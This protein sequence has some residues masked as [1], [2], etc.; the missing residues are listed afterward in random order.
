MADD[1]N[2]LTQ[3]LKKSGGDGIETNYYNILNRRTAMDDVGDAFTAQ[4]TQPAVNGKQKMT[5]ALM[6]GVGAGFKASQTHIRDKK[7][8]EVEGMLKEVVD[9]RVKLQSQLGKQQLTKATFANYAMDN[10]GDFKKVNDALAAND[11]VAVNELMPL[12]Y[13]R[14]SEQSPE[15]AKKMGKIDHVYGGKAYFDKDG[16]VSGVP[17]KDIFTPL[18]S[19]LPE[20]Q[21]RELANLTSLTM[22]NKFAKSDLFEDLGIADKRASINAHNASAN[23]ANAH[24]DYYTAEADKNKREALNPPK[25]SAKTADHITKSSA[26]WINK[27]GDENIQLAGA[28]KAYTDMI[29]LFKKEME[30]GGRAGVSFWAAVKRAYD[31][32]GS[33]SSRNQALLEMKKSPLMPEFKQIYGHIQ[34]EGDRKDFLAMLPSLNKDP[35]AS[36]QEATERAEKLKLTIRRNQIRAKVL[37]E[38]FDLNELYNGAAVTRRVE[39]IMKTESAGDL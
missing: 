30:N 20:E 33:E 5:N 12:L 25:R 4:S 38:E 29:P 15:M 27:V 1:D 13:N 11:E 6:A 17:L 36:I 35:V 37:E 22:R 32:E 23:Q 18:I 9:Q 26:D 24:A 2:I 39:E 16:K 21:Q 3:L 31:N 34:S 28:Q 8:Q 7:M 19:S 14:F 10:Y